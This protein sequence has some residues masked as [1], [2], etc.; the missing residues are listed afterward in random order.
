MLQW[1]D[2]DPDETLGYQINWSRRLRSG[3]SISSSIWE[4]AGG[5]TKVEDSF[6]GKTTTIWLSGGTSGSKYTLTNRVNTVGARVMDQS[7]SIKIKSK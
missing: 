7:V 3:D 2:K 1:P 6:D 5:L 4:V